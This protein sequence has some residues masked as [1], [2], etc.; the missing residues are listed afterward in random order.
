VQEQLNISPEEFDLDIFFRRFKKIAEN[1]NLLFVDPLPKFQKNANSVALF[2]E[3][4]YHFNAAAHQI[5]AKELYETISN[6]QLF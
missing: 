3:Y 6:Y 4:H 5:L 1:Q 2:S